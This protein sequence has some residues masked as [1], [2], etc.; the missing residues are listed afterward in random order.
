MPEDSEKIEFGENHRRAISVLMRGTER[1][2]DDAT[3]WLDR[4][5]SLLTEVRQDVEPEQQA[6]LRESIAEI[7]RTI[8]EFAGKVSLENSRMS[9]RRSVAAIV[10][11]ALI[12]LQEVQDSGLKG[13][14]PLPDPSKKILDRY[15]A[16]MAD[17]LKQMLQ[18]LG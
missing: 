4:H 12:D 17:L 9:Q 13:Y 6:L 14:G 5:S 18:I 2:C 1:A 15:L 8:E 3:E 16:R 7:R 10:S 11:G